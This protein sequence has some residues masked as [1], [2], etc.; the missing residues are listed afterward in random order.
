MS[1]MSKNKKVQPGPD[2][3][4]ELLQDGEDFSESEQSKFVVLLT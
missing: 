1:E 4:F 2:F 3:D